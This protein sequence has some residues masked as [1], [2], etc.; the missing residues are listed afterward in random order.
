MYIYFFTNNTP[1]HCSLT[2]SVSYSGDLDMGSRDVYVSSL[3]L[4]LK[5][6][7]EKS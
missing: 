2:A 3:A 7:A 5:F 4:G 6:C 1:L